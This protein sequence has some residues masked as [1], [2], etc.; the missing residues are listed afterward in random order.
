[1]REKKS[2]KKVIRVTFSEKMKWD[3]AITIRTLAITIRT[4]TMIIRTSAVFWFGVLFLFTLGLTDSF[5]LVFLFIF[6]I[7]QTK[8][9]VMNLWVISIR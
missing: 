2:E 9:L 1:M 4:P 3:L 7:Y 5:D 6:P 8:A